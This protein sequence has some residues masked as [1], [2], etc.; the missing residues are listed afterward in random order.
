M[1][2]RMITSARRTIVI[3]DASKFGFNAFAQV[4]PLNAVDILVTDKDPPMDLRQA[5]NQA[6]VE[7]IIAN[8]IQP[9]MDA[10]LRE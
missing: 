1:M 9:R 5:L 6:N 7:I 8:Q 3:A 2:A 4:A 10:N